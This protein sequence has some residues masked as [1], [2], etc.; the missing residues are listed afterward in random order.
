MSIWADFEYK[1]FGHNRSYCDVCNE[2]RDILKS[3]GDNVTFKYPGDMTL[4][5]LVEELQVFGNRMEAGLSDK[6]DV[7]LLPEAVQA[8]KKEFKKLKEEIR[9]LEREKEVLNDKNK[10]D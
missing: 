3:R 9:K 4:A 6:R 5:T 2:M 8:A 10:K 1:R 7:R